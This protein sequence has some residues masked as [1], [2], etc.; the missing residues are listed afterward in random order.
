M[1]NILISVLAILAVAILFACSKDKE[2]ERFRLL[3]AHTWRS[4]SLLVNGE[5]ASGPGE[6]LEKF[7][8]DARF[9]K[10]GSGYFGI[11]KGTWRFSYGE[12]NIVI[13]SD[14]LQLPV[15]AKIILLTQSDFKITTIY[16]NLLNPSNP[17][18]I[19]MTFKPKQ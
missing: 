19:R 18:N 6:M 17:Y 4:D 13:E 8:G 9:E 3:T 16:P 10:D 5:D 2:S 11:Y 7:K 15:T 12:A 1:K 14:S